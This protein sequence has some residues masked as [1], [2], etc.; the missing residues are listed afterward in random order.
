MTFKRLLLNCSC[1]A[2]ILF[3]AASLANGNWLPFPESLPKPDLS[4]EKLTKQWPQLTRS[5]MDRL[6]ESL[7]LQDAWRSHFEG[8]FAEA[9]EKGL[10]L[11]TPEGKYVAYRAQTIY[12]M[13]LTP[14][15]TQL[16]SKRDK[17][18]RTVLLKEAY[19]QLSN[20]IRKLESAGEKPSMQLRFWSSYIFARY[21]EIMKSE[22]GLFEKKDRLTE[23]WDALDKISGSAADMPSLRAT[24]GGTIAAVSEDGYLAR[25]TFQD[26]VK[27]CRGME[28]SYKDAAISQ[29]N[30]ALNRLG[31]NPVPEIMEAY[32]TALE[33]LGIEGG[34][35]T[36][37]KTSQTYRQYAAGARLPENTSQMV[38]MSEDI[39]AR[40]AAKKL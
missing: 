12:A 7:E 35:S 10:A 1:I 28:A 27:D 11:G 15:P 13:Y 23:L 30:C 37:A 19:D 14:D 29:F 38:F 22:W 6:P 3:S 8:D 18:Q 31:G 32:A 16:S 39:L 2:G 40:E 25:K 33:R 21:L 34:S 17:A 4:G 24:Y 9:K 36:T 5:T 26:R 20:E